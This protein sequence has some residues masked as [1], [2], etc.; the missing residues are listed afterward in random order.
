MTHHIFRRTL[1]AAAVI[2]ML[3]AVP[4]RARD[5]E[6]AQL[7]ADVRMLQEQA[8]QL[9]N[10]LG[11]LS[12]ALKAINTR[13]DQQADANRKA[14]ADAKLLID[15]VTNDLRVVREKVD[16]NNVR[17]GNLTQEVD[18]LRQLVQ[19]G[20]AKAAA[21]PPLG[22]PDL[23]GAAGSTPAGTVPAPSAPIVSGQSPTRL[24]Q[25][26]YGDYT[27]S[28]WDLAV[29]GFEAYIR[30]FPRGDKASEAQFL[31]GRAYLQSGKNDKAVESLDKLIRT[32]P[33]SAFVPDA[34]YM[35]GLS[36]RGLK[37]ADRAREAFDY[38][39]KTYPDSVAATLAKQA[40]TAR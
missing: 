26:A 30:E 12:E 36:L 40:L 3:A 24:W 14:F 16:D 21:A 10:M 20:L 38:V 4:A 17:V 31:I 7:A 2:S 28:L 25:Q 39:V 32:Y 9:Q 19:Q 23:G 6:T 5:K 22:E 35:K 29:D 18:S 11:T 1:L 37:Q 33:T 34:Y 15:N 27:A 8:Q 13:L